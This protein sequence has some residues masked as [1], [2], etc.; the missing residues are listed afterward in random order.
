MRRTLVILFTVFCIALP[1]RVPAGTTAMGEHC[2]HM[3]DMS[4]PAQPDS[5]RTHDCCNDAATVA[6]TGQLCKTG[7]ECSPSLSYLVSSILLTSAIPVAHAQRPAL[8]P[9]LHVGPPGAV[10]RPPALS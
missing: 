4:A 3:Q 1:L 2:P 5:G 9:Q 6:K 10:W 8:P 7:Y